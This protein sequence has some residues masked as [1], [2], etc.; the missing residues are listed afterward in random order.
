MSSR[1]TSAPHLSGSGDH[2]VAATDLG[3][4]LEVALEGEQR[5]ERP[6]HEGLVVGQQHLDRL[7]H[8]VTSKVVP[9]PSGPVA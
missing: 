5:R 7:A 1:H 8:I 9:C 3:H 2:L 4:H 6:S